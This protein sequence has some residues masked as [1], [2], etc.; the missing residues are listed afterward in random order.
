MSNIIKLKRSSTP[1]SI[2]ATSALV[3]GELALNTHDGK[4][5]FKKTVSGIDSIVSFQQLD[6]GTGVTILNGNINI[7]Q[8]VSTTS[9]VTFNTL[10][11][12][13]VGYSNSLK[14]DV[15]GSVTVANNLYLGGTLKDETNSTGFSGQVLTATGTGVQWQANVTTEGAIIKTFNIL[16]E[17]SGPLLGKAIFNPVAAGAIRSVQLNNGQRVIGDLTV[18]LYR[19]GDLLDFFTLPSG[20]FVARYSGFN[21]SVATNDYFTVNVVSGSGLNFSLVLLSI[22]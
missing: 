2:P 19:N 6:A 11:V 14:V 8:D 13:P 1:S 18:G 4:L 21:Y 3:S 16:N 17:F 9:N 22:S 7:G 15:T 5:F 12:S 10:T 20:E